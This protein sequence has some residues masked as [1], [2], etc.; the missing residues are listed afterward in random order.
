[1]VTILKKLSS[2]TLSCITNQNFYYNNSRNNS[3]IWGSPLEGVD[4]NYQSHSNIGMTRFHNFWSNTTNHPTNL[5]TQFTPPSDGP[6]AMRISV[7]SLT[8]INTSIGHSSPS[9]HEGYTTPKLTLVN[10]NADSFLFNNSNAYSKLVNDYIIKYGP[11]FLN[12]PDKSILDRIHNLNVLQPTKIDPNTLFEKPELLLNVLN[13][14]TT[15][16][17]TQSTSSTVTT[18]T[19]ITMEQ[20]NLDLTQYFNDDILHFVENI[21]N[22]L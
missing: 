8:S 10:S 4:I 22:F 18:T 20:I 17:T 21:N 6:S 5:I 9:V 1:M 15:S 3:S 12:L 19:P 16:S 7:D 13:S 11:E 2:N 14:V